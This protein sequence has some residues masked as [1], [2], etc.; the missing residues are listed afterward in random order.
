MIRFTIYI[1][2]ALFIG[3]CA[4]WVSSNPGQVLITWQD[5]EARFSLATMIFLALVYSMLLWGILRLLK[6]LN[7]VDFFNSPKRLAA[8][9]A[10]ADRELDLAWSAYALGD[11]KEAIK[12]G[13]RA[14]SRLGDDHNILRLLARANSQLGEVKN[15]YLNMLE[16]SLESS[17]WVE[18]Q[19]LDGLLA[20]KDWVAAKPLVKKMLVTHPKN[21]FLLRLDFLLSARTS[22]WRAADKSLQEAA[23]T[24]NAFSPAEVKHYKAVIDYCLALEERAAGKRSESLTLLK[25]ALKNDAYFA[26]AALSAARSYIEKD[27]KKS[28]EKAIASVWTH[29]PN[30]ELAETLEELYP[31]ESSSEAYRRLKKIA[32]QSPDFPESAHLLAKAAINAGHWPEAHRALENLVNNKKATKTTYHLLALLEEKQK[33]DRAAADKLRERAEKATPDSHWRCSACQSPADHYKPICPKCG[34]FDQIKWTAQ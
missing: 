11:Y 9:R 31:L 1:F 26:P 10:K 23:K 33:K 22:D 15:P 30:N 17:V 3:L 13:L 24:K 25:S 32:G 4:Y 8:K 16:A 7:I 12:L 29:A 2:V 21:A 27:D 19:R 34:E 5:W 6:W 14:K 18:K 28:A 20:Q